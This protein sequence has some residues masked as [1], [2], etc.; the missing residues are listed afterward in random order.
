MNGVARAN[1]RNYTFFRTDGRFFN[2]APNDATV[3]VSFHANRGRNPRRERHVHGSGGEDPRR[4]R[5]PRIRSSACPSAR[6]EPSASRPTRRWRSSAARATWIRPASCRGRSERSRS[7]RSLLSFLMSADAGAV[8]TGIRQNA[9]F[10]TNVGFAAG[11][12]GAEYSLTL[13]SASGATV[14]TATALSAPSAGRSRTSR[15]SSRARRF[16]TTRRC[17]SR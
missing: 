10:R 15:T 16:R 14:A 17:R 3:T 6:P 5:R 11:A 8:V 13:K 2:P 12:D 1:G 4:R 9:A 7:P